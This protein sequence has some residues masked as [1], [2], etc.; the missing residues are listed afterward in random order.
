MSESLEGYY[1]DYYSSYQQ[2]PPPSYAYA[3]PFAPRFSAFRAPQSAHHQLQIDGAV[4]ARAESAQHHH[5]RMAANKSR[6]SLNL[7]PQKE[8]SDSR[9]RNSLTQLNNSD[10]TAIDLGGMMITN[11]SPPIF[12]YN[13]LTC[14]YLNHNNLRS[15]SPEIAKLTNLQILNLTG[16]KFTILPIELGL[17]VSLKELLL[18]DNQISYLPPELGHLYRLEIIGLEGNPMT[19]PIA[20][21]IQKDGT[22]AV[23]TYL[24]DICP[25]SILLILVGSP[26]ADREWIMLE[27]ENQ[28]ANSAGDIFLISDI[29]T[30]MCYNT[31]SEKYATPQAYAYTPSWALAWD[32]RKDLLLQDILNYNADIV[33]LQVF[34]FFMQEIEAGQFEDFFK[35][36]LSH[37]AEYDGV[38]YQK[39]RARTMGEQERASVDG[40]ATFFK[41]TK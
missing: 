20:T 21:M 13:F 16:N 40:C 15:L 4:Q 3:P 1:S 8:A 37:L 39:S 25:G 23:I 38:F 10:W 36:Q 18:F 9:Q 35:E 19:D 7:V 22:R 32:Y 11:L 24:R 28:S 41:K 17:V 14:L 12:Q 29:F 26:P 5:A 31:L 6:M 33:C 34:L 27:E 2:S 30:V